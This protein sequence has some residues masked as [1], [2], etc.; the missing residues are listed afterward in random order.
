MKN[1]HSR[2]VGHWALPVARC[3]TDWRREGEV[4]KLHNLWNR[5][6]ITLFSL[7]LF[8]VVFAY[9]RY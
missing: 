2:G 6:L 5:V 3:M 1:D 8:R 9:V 7:A 4:N